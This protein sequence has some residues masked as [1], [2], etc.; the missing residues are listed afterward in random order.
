[1]R[2]SGKIVLGACA[3]WLGA[4]AAH[5]ESSKCQ[6]ACENAGSMIEIRKCLANQTKK[7]DALLADAFKKLIAKHNASETKWAVPDLKKVQVSW[8]AYRADRC[9]A[10]GK[11]EGVGGSAAGL[12][13]SICTCEET[14]RRFDEVRKY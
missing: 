10:E 8:A 7:G 13:A 3:C 2:H 5:A 11:M 6:P 4:T 14:Y 12:P 1:M 9:S